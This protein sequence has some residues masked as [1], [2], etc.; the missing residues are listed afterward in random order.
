MLSSREN[1]GRTF[2]P[3]RLETF[4]DHCLVIVVLVCLAFG[5]LDIEC[6]IHRV[7]CLKQAV[8]NY[9]D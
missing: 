9:K 5:I 3:E 6:I 4:Q 1:L 2:G 7:G 8:V